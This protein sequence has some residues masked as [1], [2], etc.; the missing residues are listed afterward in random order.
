MGATA[1]R[2]QNDGREIFNPSIGSTRGSFAYGLS[3][4]FVSANVSG[5]TRLVELLHRRKQSIPNAGSVQQDDV[6]ESGQIFGNA[7]GSAASE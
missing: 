4:S 1:I 2:R 6:R 5:R 3:G 7:L